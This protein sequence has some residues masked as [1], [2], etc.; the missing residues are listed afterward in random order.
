MF[1]PKYLLFTIVRILKGHHI[2]DCDQFVQLVLLY[3]PLFI[4]VL[5]HLVKLLFHL[6]TASYLTRGTLL[7]NYHRQILHQPNN[8]HKPQLIFLVKIGLKT[9]IIRIIYRKY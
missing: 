2:V 4:C 9:N 5:C 8:D 3:L 7:N 1:K 6:N